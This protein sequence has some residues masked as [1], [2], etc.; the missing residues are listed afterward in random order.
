M[1]MLQGVI[2]STIA[3]SQS[4]HS[5]IGILGSVR[6]KNRILQWLEIEWQITLVSRS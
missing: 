1:L 3:A 6:L 5:I 4:E 2:G